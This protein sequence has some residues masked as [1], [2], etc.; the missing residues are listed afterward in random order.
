MKTLSLTESQ[1][2]GLDK[3]ADDRAVVDS[4]EA[5]FLAACLQELGGKINEPWQFDKVH[6]VFYLNVPESKENE[7]TT[8]EPGTGA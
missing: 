5:R 8:A 3:Y 1:H 4:R 2:L 7:S 6:R